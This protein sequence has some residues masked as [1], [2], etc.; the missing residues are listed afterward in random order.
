MAEFKINPALALEVSALRNCGSLINGGYSSV[1][2]SDVSTLKTAARLISQ[3]SNIK[4]MLDSYK[5]LVLRDALDLDEMA[6]T[7]QEMD[8]TLFASGNQNDEGS[9]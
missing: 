9:V 1:S 8:T 5:A 4:R 7:A 6:Q 2:S 3:H